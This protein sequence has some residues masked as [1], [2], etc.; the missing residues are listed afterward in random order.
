[1]A[2]VCACGC[3]ESPGADSRG[4]PRRWVPGHAS[5][6]F[7]VMETQL[8]HRYFDRDD[9]GRPYSA[10]EFIDRIEANAV[11]R[12]AIEQAVE[13]V[14]AWADSI[15]DRPHG[16]GIRYEFDR[17]SAEEIIDR[18]GLHWTRQVTLMV[19]VLR[20]AKECGFVFAYHHR[21]SVRGRVREYAS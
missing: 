19:A 18:L 7:V 8:E 4:R 10:A 13:S 21:P 5:R 1:M 15:M 17:D 2:R 12:A 14:R 20:I 3:G 9:P 11:E 16:E 6:A